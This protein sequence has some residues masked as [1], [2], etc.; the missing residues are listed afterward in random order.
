MAGI[1]VIAEARQGELREVSFELIA[2]GLEL[3][4]A[5]G[6]PLRWR[7]STP[8]RVRTRPRWAPTASTR[9]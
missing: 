2:A 9:C 3:K 7:S 8:K 6:G 4:A 1:L 5:A